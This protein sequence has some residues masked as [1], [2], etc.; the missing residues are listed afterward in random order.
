MGTHAGHEGAGDQLRDA[1]VW[2]CQVLRSLG[3]MMPSLSIIAAS[4]TSF[5]N[6]LNL[7]AV[8]QIVFSVK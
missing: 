3:P 7:F 5:G 2:A 6:L 1:S 4:S 8:S